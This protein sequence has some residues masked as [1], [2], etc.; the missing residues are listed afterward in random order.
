MQ[1]FLLKSLLNGC[2]VDSYNLGSNIKMWCQK[3]VWCSSFWKKSFSL[4][5]SQLRVG[6]FIECSL[7]QDIEFPRP[8]QKLC[9]TSDSHLSFVFH[10]YQ[11]W[12]DMGHP[13][14]LLL[15][16]FWTHE[17]SRISFPVLDVN[18]VVNSILT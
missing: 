18:K 11:L 12:N 10:A 4:S 3:S 17:L 5:G 14:L 16:P 9:V 7:C 1:S 8:S 13:P 6:N 15:L 2:K